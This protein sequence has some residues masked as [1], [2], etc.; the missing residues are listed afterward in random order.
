MMLTLCFCDPY[1]LLG[2]KFRD[3]HNV[4]VQS[5]QPLMLIT[6]GT[7]I[8]VPYPQEYRLAHGLIGRMENFPH[9]HA[10]YA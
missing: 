9:G 6:L 3:L 5:D 7:A 8:R 4:K 1:E 10:N 2:T